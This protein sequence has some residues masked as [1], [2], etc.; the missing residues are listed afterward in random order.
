MLRQ[1]SARAKTITCGS[2]GR[3]SNLG[4]R[5]T[6][7]SQTRSS[8][9]CVIG[10]FESADPARLLFALLTIFPV[11]KGTTQQRRK[12]VQCLWSKPSAK[13]WIYRGASICA[14][15]TI[16]AKGSSTNAVVT[17]DSGSIC[18]P[19]SAP[20]AATSRWPGSR[21]GCGVPA[22]AAGGSGLLRTA[23]RL[24]YSA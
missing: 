5:S 15:W 4:N 3:F 6:G 7:S 9:K 22:A 19:L 12:A 17:F 14:A 2:V 10:C 1:A 8:E 11:V 13:P 24:T 20:A 18:K 16:A 21:S 23:E